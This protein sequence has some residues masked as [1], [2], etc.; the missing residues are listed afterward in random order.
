MKI[1]SISRPPLREITEKFH[2]RRQYILKRIELMGHEVESLVIN[3]LRIPNLYL[4]YGLGMAFSPFRFRKVKPDLILADNLESS[5]AAVLIKSI[6]KIPFVF[7]FVDD[8]SLIASYEGRMLRYQALKHLEKVIPELAD[9]VIVVDPQKEQFCLDIGIPEQKLR[10]VP[11]GVDTKRFEPGI[12]NTTTRKELNL[13]GNKVVLFVGK[14]NKYYNLEVLLKAIPYV[15]KGFPNTKFLFIG[16]GND[17]NHLKEL[18]HKLKVEAAVIFTGFLPVEEIPKII[19]LSNVCFYPLPNDGALAIFECMACAKPLVL[20]R[21]GTNKMGISEEIIPQD[22]ALQVD[23]S[24]EGF[25][26]GINF[27]LSNEEIGKE[28]G[29]KA[30]E[31]A[32]RLHDWNTLAKKYE[33]A[34]KEVLH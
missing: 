12:D 24:P 29:T 8:Y 7:N 13:N 19:N 26:Q 2:T 11:N 10:M 6:F 16:D 18:T 23:G 14:I 21:G 22:C 17:L 34:L 30:R 4:A 25:A 20:P 31:R 27:L 33:K 32:V 1:C 9:L 5:I 3:P 28:M 15:L